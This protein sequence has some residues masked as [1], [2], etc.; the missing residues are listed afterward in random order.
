M[1]DPTTIDQFL[2]LAANHQQMKS[3]RSAALPEKWQML[4]RC[5]QILWGEFPIP[6]KS[7]VQAAVDLGQMRF[8]CSCRGR[9]HPCEHALGLALLGHDGW[10]MQEGAPPNWVQDWH[11]ALPVEPVG[12]EL[13]SLTDEEVPARRYQQKQESILAGLQELKLWLHDLVRGGLVIARSQP[14]QNWLRM[15]DRLVDAQASK[16][17]QDIRD[18]SLIPGKTPNWPEQLLRG[19]GRLYLLIEGYERFDELP[20]DAQADLRAAVGWFPS[21]PQSAC[22]LTNDRWHILA[23]DIRQQKKQKTQRIWL[24]GEETNQPALLEKAIYGKEPIN[25]DLLPGMVLDADL[26]YY[27]SRTPLRTQIG[28][29]NRREQATKRIPAEGS[30]QETM[31][32]YAQRLALNP[33]LGAYPTIVQPLSVQKAESGWMMQDGEGSLLPLPPKF[34]HGWHLAAL[35]HGGALTIFG[36]WDGHLFTPLSVWTRDGFWEIR[37]LR[38]LI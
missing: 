23:R 14:R 9:R 21:I 24:W 2:S 34:K 3:S 1:P 27:P 8:F 18:L 25:T 31:A 7:T 38:G 10:Q 22:H 19:I 30:F 11:H 6:K 29:T 13:L 37:R 16:V 28:A 20:P 4:A 32:D 15:A 26:V 33:W 12:V 35:S 5:K 36:Q 17:A